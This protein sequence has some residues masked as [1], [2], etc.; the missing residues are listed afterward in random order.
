MNPR[1]LVNELELA[2]EGR[3]K[4]HHRFLLRELLG[5]LRYLAAAEERVE[6][7]IEAHMR[8]FETAATIWD[9]IPGIDRRVAQAAAAEIG[10]RMEQFPT[11]GHL[12]SWVG[13]CPGHHES[14]GKQYSGKTT[15]GNVW[16]RRILIQAAWSA[17]RTKNC[18]FNSLYH[19]LAGRRGKKRAIVAVAHSMLVVMYHTLKNGVLYDELGADFF[20]RTNEER[21]VRRSVQRLS[22]LGYIVTLEK[23]A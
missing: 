9:A 10:I 13:F 8:P 2:L 20:E 16:L 12:S 3:V 14:A 22:K 7:E 23:A 17:S 21:V 19:R 4:A 1:E 11:A 15:D 5:Q 18:Y 6:I